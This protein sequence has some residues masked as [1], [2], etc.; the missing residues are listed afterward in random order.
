VGAGHGAN[1]VRL[2]NPKKVQT[3]SA[4]NHSRHTAEGIKRR[5]T[6]VRL[7]KMRSPETQWNLNFLS[8]GLSL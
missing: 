7:Q 2:R 5:S 4:A 6:Q 8:K 3:A 1:F